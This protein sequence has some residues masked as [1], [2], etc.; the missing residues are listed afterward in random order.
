MSESLPLPDFTNIGTSSGGGGSTV[1][2][3]YSTASFV[4]YDGNSNIEVTIPKGTLDVDVY[5]SS[6]MYLPINSL[7]V[8]N[9]ATGTSLVNGN[10]IKYITAYDT[11]YSISITYKLNKPGNGNYVNLRQLE[12]S[13]VDASGASYSDEITKKNLTTTNVHRLMYL[14]GN[15]H[16]VVNDTARLKFIVAQN[17]TGADDTDTV[18]TI[19]DISILCT[20]SSSA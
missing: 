14:Q 20:L 2:V 9:M 5:T 13:V 17:T 19:F 4:R 12:C 7:N 18:M 16:H 8:S 10:E 1:S 11:S 3:N 15:V 6:S